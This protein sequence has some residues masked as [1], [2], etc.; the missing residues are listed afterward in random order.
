M[1]MNLILIL[2]FNFFLDILRGTSLHAHSTIKNLTSNYL[3]LNWKETSTW[4]FGNIPHSD[5]CWCTFWWAQCL[6][7]LMIDIHCK[8][9]CT[10][11]NILI[12]EHTKTA[13][14]RWKKLHKYKQAPKNYAIVI[15]ILIVTYAIILSGKKNAII[16]HIFCSGT[17]EKEKLNN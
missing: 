6:I 17:G 8:H 13:S 11:C 16:L 15:S 12:A 10:D 4:T 1:I 14:Q 2:T 9:P 7:I 5:R 3:Y